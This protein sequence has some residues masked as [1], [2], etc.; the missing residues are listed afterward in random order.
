[1]REK[2]TGALSDALS[3]FALSGAVRLPQSDSGIQIIS[4]RLRCQIVPLSDCQ[5][6]T[7]LMT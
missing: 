4:M 3:D 5:N 7:T 2:T 6:L 1:M